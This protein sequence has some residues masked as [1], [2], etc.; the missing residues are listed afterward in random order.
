MIT[1]GNQKMGMDIAIY[2]ITLYVYSCDNKE[3]RITEA[4]SFHDSF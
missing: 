1:K 2:V 4:S 3:K